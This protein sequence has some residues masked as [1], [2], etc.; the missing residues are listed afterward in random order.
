MRSDIAR[1]FAGVSRC[2]FSRRLRAGSFGFA[3]RV[4]PA[5]VDNPS[6][7]AEVERLE[8]TSPDAARFGGLAGAISMPNISER[9]SLASTFA[10]AGCLPF[11]QRSMAHVVRRCASTMCRR[12]GADDHHGASCEPDDVGR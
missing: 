3:A 8:A 2:V 4:T 12:T 1:R 5:C 7:S 10:P 9:S 11:F 6:A